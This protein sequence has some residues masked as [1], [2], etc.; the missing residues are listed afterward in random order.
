MPD[1]PLNKEWIVTVGPLV[2][3]TDFKTLET[4]VAYN[5]AGMSVDLIKTNGAGSTKFD[6]TLSDAGQWA[7]AHKGSGVYSISISDAQNNT[8]G[9]LRVVGVA[10]GVL[11]FESPVYAVKFSDA[12][13]ALNSDVTGS[14]RSAE[15]DKTG[16]ALSAASKDAVASDTWVQST[17]VLT[18]ATNLPDSDVWAAGT[19][20]LTTPDSDFHAVP[21]DIWNAAARALT[22]KAGFALSTAS[23]D[24][25]ASDTW[26]QA[27]RTLTTPLSDFHAVPSDI[28]GAGTRTL[29][30]DTNLNTLITDYNLDH[31]AKVGDA[32]LSGVLANNTILAHIVAVGGDVS[33]YSN[34]TDSLEA[35]RDRGDSAWTTG[36]GGSAPTSDAVAAAVW[37][38][39]NRALTAL[40]DF[41]LSTTS[42]DAVAS[43]VWVQGTKDVNVA[44]WNDG[45][46]PVISTKDE[47]ASDVW[48]QSTRVL[49]ADTNLNIPDSDV[50]A[51]GTRT[52]TTPLSDFH[53]VPSDTW[54][55][56]ARTL[57]TPDSDF[58]AVPSDIWNAADR[59]LTNI[60][61]IT[62]D[63][64]ST[65]MSDVDAT[66]QG[67][68]MYTVVQAIL[69]SK[70]V[71]SDWTI[72]KTDGTTTHLTK[73]VTSDVD[74]NPIT[75]VQ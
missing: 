57:T 64:L 16:F 10:D 42:K 19:R 47:I 40:S 75:R 63:F 25:V 9:E 73:K 5:A 46:V 55:A 29:T 26:A 51:A 45:S 58:H 43:D 2:D 60:S 38:E 24:A 50:W 13:Y 12:Y 28:W 34:A 1:I 17:R 59:G 53:A 4:S 48:V 37:T 67:G 6:I 54:G 20:T 66:A 23:K 33:D 56:A 36:G 49:T 71:G 32:D 31:L 65:S 35:I 11:P 62:R 52:L 18:A 44:S 22:D 30:S 21:S 14:V 41:A 69:E 61:D 8:I 39:T 7:W 27:S 15:I 3:D 68:S 72:Y 70:I 74:A